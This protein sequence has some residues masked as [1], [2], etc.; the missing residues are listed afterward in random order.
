[1]LVE[2]RCTPAILIL[3]CMPP[4]EDEWVSINEEYATLKHCGYW[5][6]LSGMEPSTNSSKKRI[7]IP[8]DQIFTELALKYIMSR[9][10]SGDSL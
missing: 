9:V 8:K 1:M 5:M 2:K 10:E 3:Y 6:S 4:N 7:R